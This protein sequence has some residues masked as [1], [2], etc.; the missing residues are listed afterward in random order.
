MF[1]IQSDDEELQTFVSKRFISSI[2]LET[3]TDNVFILRD[4]SIFNFKYCA[5]GYNKTFRSIEAKA[6]YKK[7]KMYIIVARQEV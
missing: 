6:K 3:S 4:L 7:N 5:F 1:N 2:H